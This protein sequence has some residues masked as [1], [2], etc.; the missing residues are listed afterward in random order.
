VETERPN[1]T[2]RWS[3][4]EECAQSAFDI[5]VDQP[6]L[7]WAQQAWEHLGR[8]GLASYTDELE[9]CRVKIRFLALTGLYHDWCAVAWQE[10]ENPTY[11]DWAELLGISP[12]RLG[13]LV[14]STQMELDGEAEDDELFPMGL[15]KMIHAHRHEVLS[16]LLQAYGNIHDLFVSLWNS[17]KTDVRA[18][19]D[20]EG[21]EYVDTRKESAYEILNFDIAEKG[22]GYDWLCQGAE[23]LLDPY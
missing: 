4:L 18:D 19:H 23:E 22:P 15:Q 10:A 6:E 13:Q 2:L 5:W 3:E 9:K 7:S 8:Q 11:S 1:R 14:G 17:N 12:F 16:S 21:G 20:A